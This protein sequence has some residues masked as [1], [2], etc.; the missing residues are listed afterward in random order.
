MPKYVTIRGWL[1]DKKEASGDSNN[2]KEASDYCINKK[3]AS[4]DSNNF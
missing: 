4:D 3:E 1:Y 2:E